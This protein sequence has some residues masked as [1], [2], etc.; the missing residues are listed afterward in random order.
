MT[1]LLP[2][3]AVSLLNF[4]S[5]PDFRTAKK[6]VLSGVMEKLKKFLTDT[7]KVLLAISVVTATLL[8]TLAFDG[9]V[10]PFVISFT[11]CVFVLFLKAL[12]RLIL[13]IR[14]FV[15]LKKSGCIT[16]KNKEENMFWRFEFLI[17][18][19]LFFIAG[20]FLFSTICLIT[21]TVWR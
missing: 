13:T 8:Y 16:G 21:E 20:Y 17:T 9:S 11:T 3:Y 10:T 7:W 18:V 19:G 14:A 6:G 2:I 15:C 12:K 4:K 1:L 5:P